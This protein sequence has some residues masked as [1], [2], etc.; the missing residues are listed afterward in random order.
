MK[1]LIVICTHDAEFYLVLSHI[2]AVDGFTSALTSNV[3][4]IFE[5]AAETT[6][7]ACVLDCRPDNRMADNCAR[8]R[9]DARTSA[10]PVVALIAAGAENQ[11]LALLKSG[12]NESFVRPLA[13]SKLLD[14][15]HFKLGTSPEPGVRT[16]PAM[17]L[18][19]GDVEMQV[20]SHHVRCNGRE[21]LL[22]PI[23]FRL[24]RHMLENPEKVVSRDELIAVAWPGNVYVG[25]RTVDVH[26]SRLR[27]SLKHSSHGDIIRTVRLGGYA[28]E[29]HP[30]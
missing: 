30:F 25:P 24:L 22:G 15:L 16:P 8:L 17:S 11:H 26:I 19:Y 1:P 18:K 21:I 10:L 20:D 2:L 3:D 23:E 7:R 4:E 14:Y 9:Q 12:I 5:L 29:Y 13:P 27:K 28:L 6:V